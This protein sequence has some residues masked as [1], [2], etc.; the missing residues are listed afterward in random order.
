M[1]IWKLKSDVREHKFENE[2]SRRLNRNL[3]NRLTIDAEMQTEFKFV[4]KMSESDMIWPRYLWDTWMNSIPERAKS[5]K[6]NKLASALMDPDIEPA[7]A[8]K[9]LNWQ[10]WNINFLFF[11]TRLSMLTYIYAVMIFIF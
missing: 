3:W 8:V 10:F 4:E 11:F 9:K 7:T 1:L 2:T 6:I 5:Q